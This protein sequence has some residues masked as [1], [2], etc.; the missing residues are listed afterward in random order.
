MSAM[1]PQVNE[2]DAIERPIMVKYC[3]CQPYDSFTGF[4][5]IKRYLKLYAKL[6]KLAACNNADNPLAGESSRCRGCLRNR[7]CAVAS[8]GMLA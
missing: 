3:M 5:V 1:R 7:A 2:R 8:E 4:G 6:T